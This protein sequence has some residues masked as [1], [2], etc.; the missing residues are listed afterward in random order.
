MSTFDSIKAL[1]NRNLPESILV[2]KLK[3]VV[4]T[5][6]NPNVLA[7]KDDYG[8]TLLH[9]ASYN[10]K[11]YEL[12]R[13]LH[14]L[15]PALV[16]TA[17]YGGRLPIHSACFYGNVDTAKYLLQVYP[18]SINIPNGHG[19]YPLHM[20]VHGRSPT[21]NQLALAKFL[22]EKDSGTLSSRNLRGSVPMHIACERSPFGIVQFLFDAY[23][24]AVSSYNSRGRTPLDLAKSR[25]R[26]DVVSFLQAQLQCQRRALHG[27]RKFAIHRALQSEAASP[28]GI[29]LALSAYPAGLRVADKDGNLPLHVACL[30]GKC[31]TVNYIL[32]KTHAYGVT[33]Q[34]KEKKMPLELL[35]YDAICDRESIDYVETL[36]RLTQA[37][38]SVIVTLLSKNENIFY[39]IN[40]LWW[41]GIIFLLCLC[42]WMLVMI[43][44][45][46][47]Y[48]HEEL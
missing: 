39:G 8:N 27:N 37:E 25:N 46:D 15:D 14:D 48:N 31:N 28:G 36:M 40:F 32:E 3:E 26:S 16:Q 33:L 41:I 10:S 23:P 9:Y 2:S 17:N 22:I 34:N 7:T 45:S 30:L 4:L 29:K 38:P 24:E 18:E 13:I 44:F 35:L 42:A 5:P 12:C 43:H 20:L 21:E 19:F 11:C 1:C 47:V 6:C